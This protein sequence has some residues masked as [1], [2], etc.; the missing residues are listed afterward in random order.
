MAALNISDKVT[1]KHS[2]NI[3]TNVK[4][5]TEYY[6]KYDNE[7]K[8]I[9]NI[10]TVAN[11][12]KLNSRDIETA[13]A[14]VLFRHEEQFNYYLQYKNV[15]K[16]PDEIVSRKLKNKYYDILANIEFG[17]GQEQNRGS[18]YWFY[19]GITTYLQNGAT[20]K[21]EEEKFKHIYEG[22]GRELNSLA[23]RYLIEM[24]A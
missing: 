6:A 5:M 19:N 12:V 11:K 17:V 18:L 9:S 2:K 10:Y 15:D 16:I 21:S 22:K 8:D 14:T 4:L 20:Y 3:N 13:L 23:F 1:F 7:I 24:A